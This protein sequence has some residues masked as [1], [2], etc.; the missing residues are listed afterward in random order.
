MMKDGAEHFEA[1]EEA[2]L[3]RKRGRPKG[4]G[5]GWPRLFQAGEREFVNRI[6]AEYH[7]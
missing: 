4:R 3:G 7:A 6:D 2:R 5:A 1:S